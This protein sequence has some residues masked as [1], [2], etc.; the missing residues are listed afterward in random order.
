MIRKKKEKVIRNPIILKHIEVYPNKPLDEEQNAA[1]QKLLY[2][3]E[4]HGCRLTEVRFVK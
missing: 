2:Y 1:M 3:A 4:E